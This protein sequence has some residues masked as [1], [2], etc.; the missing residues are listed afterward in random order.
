[1]S[2]SC[3]CICKIIFSGY[4]QTEMCQYGISGPTTIT[5]NYLLCTTTS[6]S[7]TKSLAT[8]LLTP[9]GTQDR[10]LSFVNYLEFRDQVSYY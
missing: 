4:Q 1:M 3:V 6:A 7:A 9:L 8:M 10:Q 2:S 5:D